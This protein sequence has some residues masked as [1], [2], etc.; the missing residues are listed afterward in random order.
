VLADGGRWQ[1]PILAMVTEQ[2]FFRGP[3]RVVVYLS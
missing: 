1:E 3:Q 2:G